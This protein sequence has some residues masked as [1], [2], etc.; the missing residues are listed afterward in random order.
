MNSIIGDMIRYQQCYDDV[1]ITAML[2]S[3]RNSA[4]KYSRTSMAL[5]LMTCYHGC[6]ELILESLRKKFHSC[7]FGILWVNF[8]FCI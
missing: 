2:S 7:R 8:L 3:V 4:L 5:T 1:D 6:F